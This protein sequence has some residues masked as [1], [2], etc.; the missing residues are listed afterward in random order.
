MH[1]DRKA[2]AQAG[3]WG[4]RPLL[5]PYTRSRKSSINYILI[6][7]LSVDSPNVRLLGP[8]YSHN[9]TPLVR[10]MMQT[11]SF[12]DLQMKSLFTLSNALDTSRN[13]AHSGSY[14]ALLNCVSLV[15]IY[16]QSSFL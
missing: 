14:I 9:I 11:R 3:W 16:E 2:Q 13:D 10:F 7:V 5:F 8:F 1:M 4:N 6:L 15:I 12:K